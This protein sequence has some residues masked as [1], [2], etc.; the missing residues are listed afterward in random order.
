MALARPVGGE[1]AGAGRP[2]APRRDRPDGEHEIIYHY[3]FA[4]A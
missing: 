2:S 4:D 1:I 3:S